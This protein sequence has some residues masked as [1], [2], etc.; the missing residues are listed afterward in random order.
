MLPN[1]KIVTPGSSFL[2][3]T[4][5]SNEQRI[6][7]CSPGATLQNYHTISM[8]Y[9]TTVII[10]Y[11]F[12]EVSITHTLVIDGVSLKQKKPANYLIMHTRIFQYFKQFSLQL[13]FNEST[14]YLRVIVPTLP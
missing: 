4:N 5:T 9:S 11:I 6:K 1:S 13:R 2:F 3:F 14:I 8:V 7:I 10:Y 12:D